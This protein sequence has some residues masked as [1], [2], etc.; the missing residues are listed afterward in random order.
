LK[1]YL[2]IP[3][4]T[5]GIHVMKVLPL[6]N[7]HSHL[8]KNDV[9]THIDGKAIADDGTVRHACHGRGGRMWLVR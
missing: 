3:K 5:T 7:L 8:R 9:V 6:S 2:R 4:A 1:A